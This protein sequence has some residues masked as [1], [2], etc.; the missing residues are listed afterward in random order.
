MSDFPVIQPVNENPFNIYFTKDFDITMPA[1]IAAIIEELKSWQ[2]KLI[3]DVTPSYTSLL[4]SY[5]F[6]LISADEM[7][8]KLTVVVQTATQTA[9]DKHGQCV[10][11][12]VYY[13]PQSGLDL[14]DTANKIGISVEE[15]IELHSKPEYLVFALGFMPGFAFMGIL[16]DRL[17]LPRLS[18]PRKAVP[19]GSV[20]IAEKQTAVYPEPTPGGWRL[21]GKSPACLFDVN[22]NPTQPYQIGDR[23]KFRPIS[24]EEFLS[25]GG[26]L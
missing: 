22:N 16:N 19:A 15:L 3:T 17:I 8:Q 14:V 21:L 23:V 26:K 10:E 25:L 20:A 1:Q 4:V 6:L 9:T 7:R 5:N 12:P 13:S 24:K 18:T 2:D 11:L